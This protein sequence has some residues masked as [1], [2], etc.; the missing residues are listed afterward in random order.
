M[1][2]LTEIEALADAA[3][4]LSSWQCDIP[5]DDIKAMCQLIRQQHE[6]L[7]NSID[8]VQSE[9]DNDWRHGMPTRE[10]QLSGIKE[11]LDQHKATLAKYEEFNK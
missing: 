2:K 3:S 11:L 5:A 9:Y 10:K 8:A 4:G 7:K 1:T 6:A